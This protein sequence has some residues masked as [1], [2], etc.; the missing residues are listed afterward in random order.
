MPVCDHCLLEF[1]EREAVFADIAGKQKTFCCAGCR[2]IYLL[3]H[4]EGLGLFYEKRKWLTPSVSPDTISGPY[5][6]K[7]PDPA[8]FNKCVRKAEAGPGME[9][10]IYIDGIRCSSCVWLNEKVLAR[11]EGVQYARV[12]Y[13]THKARIRWDPGATEP[14]RILAR[15][16]SIG[17]S[18]KPYSEPE[19]FQAQRM[20]RRDLLIRF[21]TAGFLS[22]QLMIYSLALYAGYFQGIGDRTKLLFQITAML[23]TA[24]VIF[25][26]GMPFIKSATAAARHLRF[27]MDSLI[28]IGAGSSF[29]YSIYGMC[30][31]GEV[32]FDTSSM[33]ITL[34]LL[35]RYVEA[36]AKAKASETL[37]RLA[38]LAP[39]TATRLVP[40]GPAGQY[41]RHTVPISSLKKDDLVEVKPGQRIPVDGTVSEGGSE[42]DESLLTGEPKPVP[43]TTGS[44][45]I[46]G[47]TNLY[48]R[49][50]VR[51]GRTG[52]DTV[53]AGIVRAVEGAQTRRPQIQALADR[54]TGVFVPAVLL[55]AVATAVVYFLKGEPPARCLMTGVSVLVIACPCSLGLATPLAVLMFTTL[56]SSK[57]L[58]VRS[59]DV[60]ENSDGI[61]HV[62]FDK[63]GT[64]T[65]GRPALN[66]LILAD[67][68]LSEDELV[69]L[70]S[71]IESLSEHSIA[72]GVCGRAATTPVSE[73]L[74]IPGKGVQG[75][76]EGKRILIG[77]RALMEENGVP[78]N[79][80]E[81][82]SGLAEPYEKKGSTVV[83]MAWERRL[84]AAM[85]ISDTIRPEAAQAVA[86][87]KALGLSAGLL[88]GD[89]EM[90]A[91]AVARQ[92]GAESVLSAASP[93]AKME[94]VAK[95][96]KLPGRHGVLMVGD[97]IND[98]P[99]LAEA[100]VGIAMGRG[101]DLA[102]GSA[103]AVLVRNDL[104]LVP[105]F[106][107]LSRKTLGTIKQNLFWAFFYNA[108]A[109]PLA[110]SG[111]LHP[112]V[113]AGAM[114]TSSVFVVGNSLRIRKF[115]M[116]TGKKA[117]TS[118]KE[119]QE[120]M[121]GRYGPCGR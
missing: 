78:G 60:M 117:A 28:A 9:M 109:L 21:G 50:V 79:E 107:G 52:E 103:D 56:A 12:N 69:R 81:A 118:K 119:K 16:A 67:P 108:M 24:P 32:Y 100:S 83:Y 76:V 10:D 2:G 115:R 70:A 38:E 4:D 46:G 80:M 22:C 42:A 41:E 82:I 44:E 77:N 96:Q 98:A 47:S 75:V 37:E 66:K 17:Y 111:V 34:I 110:V 68:A 102:M 14:G 59:A 84:R 5:S 61:A 6:R 121:T 90:A 43:K 15:I 57:G 7:S 72:R 27:N 48:G 87:I 33:I 114:A 105:Y 18:P 49:I 54:V 99:A 91:Q 71:S 64:V 40:E 20:E 58:L 94:Y 26:S 35:G 85:I 8:L 113:A 97:G 86:Q 95:R 45:V 25:Y 116:E 88:S 19:R 65:T 73:F 30:T 1:P 53:L 62:L 55:T 120:K 93:A 31:G 92:I 39:E 3:I 51:A 112:I 74:S 13:A 11:T 104:M 89:N 63:T 23:I 106:I 29:F 36:A 101:T